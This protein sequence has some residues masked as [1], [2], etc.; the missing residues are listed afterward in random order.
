VWLSGFDFSGVPRREREHLGRKLEL[1]LAFENKKQLARLPVKVLDLPLPWRDAFM[2][3]AQVWPIEEAPG[4]ARLTPTVVLHGVS[5][6][7]H[8]L[9]VSYGVDRTTE[10][11]ELRTQNC[12]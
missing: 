10:N 2:D 4:I 11:L 3:D 8:E 9:D 1:Q 5:I 7:D 12:D 6:S